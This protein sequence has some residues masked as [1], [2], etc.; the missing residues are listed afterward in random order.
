MPLISSISAGARSF[1]LYV[2]AA[3]KTVIDTFNRANGSLGSISGQAWKVWRGTWSIS[4]NQASAT[5]PASS[6]PAAT[7]NF[8]D[9]DVT[10]GIST[11]ASGAGTVFWL[12]DADNWW[13]ATYD[14]VY[15]CQTCQG[16]SCVTYSTGCA[17]S[18]CLT[19]K[20]NAS[21]C[22]G[23]Q[24]CATTFCTTWT[25][26][27]FTLGNCTTFA[28]F[29]C[30][31]WSSANKNCTARNPA[32][33]NGRNPA[34]CNQRTCASGNCVT[35]NPCSTSVCNSSTCSTSQC[36]SPTFPCNAGNFFFFS[37]NCTTTY[38]TKL[39]K[40]VTGTIS[41]V[42]NSAWSAVVGSF[43]VILSGNNVTVRTFNTANY[44]TQIGSD[45]TT[46]ATGAV[47]NK[48]HG[49]LVAPANSSQGNTIDEFRVG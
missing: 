13:G 15:A 39:I 17:A 11:P 28:G 45:W 23:G 38:Q 30:I 1:G 8:L 42:A 21:T 7:L 31:S 41:A 33:C 22:N 12:S 26:N 35:W 5:S 49:I 36:N 37:C 4:S 6:Y 46:A 29:N 43:R 47:K 34:T 40:N 9:T 16:F 32:F 2:L 25:C 20:C 10:I 14:I 27:A 18:T 19:S 3:L 48:R 24:F 44:T